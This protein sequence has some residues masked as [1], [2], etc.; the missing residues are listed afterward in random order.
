MQGLCVLRERFFI[1]Q[2]FEHAL[3]IINWKFECER[4]KVFAFYAKNFTSYSV[5]NTLFQSFSKFSHLKDARSSLYALI[6]IRSYGIWLSKKLCAFAVRI[7][8][9]TWVNCVF[10][11]QA[12]IS[13]MK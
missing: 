11:E 6:Y 10:Y 2:R 3:P 4:C 9:N 8:Q 12:H 5:L 7:L 13:G 1:L